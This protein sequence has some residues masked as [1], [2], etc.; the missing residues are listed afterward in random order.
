MYKY[1]FQKIRIWVVS[2]K[3]VSETFC[4]CNGLVDEISSGS[5]QIMKADVTLR[6]D[7]SEKHSMWQVKEWE[8]SLPVD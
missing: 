2:I 3:L 6:K 8:G 1:R 5:L 4:W 7:S